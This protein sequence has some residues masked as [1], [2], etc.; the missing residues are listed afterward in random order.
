MQKR[1]E[2]F[3]LVIS[4]R[5]QL[6]LLFYRYI[7]KPSLCVISKYLKLLPVMLHK[8]TASF[9]TFVFIFIWHGTVWDVFVWSALNFL[10][11]TLEHLGKATSTTD[12]Y[13]WFKKEVL[14]SDEMEVRFLALVCTPLLIMSAIS[15]FYLFAGSKVGNVYFACFL[16]PSTWNSVIVTLSMYS[17]CH[18][19]IALQNVS[20]R[21][22]VKKQNV[23]C[24]AD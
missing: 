18:V 16:T 24:K 11:I 7:Y 14:R 23:H 21:T 8:L 22:D 3:S 9:A 6:L 4:N 15:N 20:T 2:E 12:A 5:F 19:S 13:K 17:C 1:K 10:G